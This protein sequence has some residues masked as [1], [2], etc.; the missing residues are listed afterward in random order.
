MKWHRITP[1]ER[2]QSCAHCHKA[3]R[4]G[5]VGTYQNLGPQHPI[6][7]RTLWWHARCIR[8]LMTDC[9]PDND[10]QAFNALRD[11]IAVTG[12]AFPD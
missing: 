5:Q 6:T 8:E 12:L 7:N 4:R 11:R 1:D 9:P 10:E 2:P 3:I